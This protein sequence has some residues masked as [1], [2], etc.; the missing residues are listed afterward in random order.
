M[1]HIMDKAVA[2]SRFECAVEDG[3]VFGVQFAG[4]F[5]GFVFVDVI[6]DCF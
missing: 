2:F 5:D 6:A 1:R 4:T 3:E